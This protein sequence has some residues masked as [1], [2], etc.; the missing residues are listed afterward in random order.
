MQ[1][2][3]LEMRKSEIDGKVDALKA[4]LEAGDPDEEE[5]KGV[6]E[7]EKKE[8]QQNGSRDQVDN[9]EPSSQAA[10]QN[11]AFDKIE[12]IRSTVRAA[13]LLAQQRIM[14]KP[15]SPFANV[16]NCLQ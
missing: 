15:V 3:A 16:K 11:N 2:Q 1:L 5:K 6:D 7:E 14:N 12:R 8:E 4:Q 13:K 10:A 9:A